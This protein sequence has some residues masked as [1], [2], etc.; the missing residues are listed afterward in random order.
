MRF[1][2][3]MRLLDEKEALPMTPQNKPTGLDVCSGPSLSRAERLA[4]DAARFTPVKPAADTNQ[5]APR[6]A[7]AE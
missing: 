4:Q 5:A 2:P 6:L 3:V 1:L 7:A